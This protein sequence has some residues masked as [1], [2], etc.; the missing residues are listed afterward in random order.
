MFAVE[1]LSI[2]RSADAGAENND[3]IK[4]KINICDTLINPN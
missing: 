3:I 1:L 2:I 4:K